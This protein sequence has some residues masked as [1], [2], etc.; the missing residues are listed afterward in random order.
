MQR[1]DFIK[2]LIVLGACPAC[3]GAGFA[4][5]GAHWSYEGQ[6]GPDHWGATAPENTACSA[7]SQQSPLDLTG[8]VKAELPPIA[9]DWK[10]GGRIVNNGHT[11]QVNM[12]GGSRL[13]RAG[14]SYELLQYHFHAPSEHHVDGRSFPMEAH[15]VHRHKETGTLGVLGVF[16]T[17]GAANSGFSRLATAFP[18]AAGGEAAVDDVDPNGLLPKELTYW[19]YEGSLTTPPCSEIVDWMVLRQ[20][21]EA[22]ENDISAFTTLYPMNARPVLAANRRFILSSF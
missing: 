10:A 18:K 17:P 22:D 7:G 2:G 20:P 1:R 4:A 3:A 5:E 13:S 12:P 19:S 8:A 16:V 11:I 6:S 9:I 21:I 14:N 15:F